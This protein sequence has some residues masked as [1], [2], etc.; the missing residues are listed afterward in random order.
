MIAPTADTLAA[1]LVLSTPSARTAAGAFWSAIRIAS[2]SEIFRALSGA[3]VS[4][5]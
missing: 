3:R 2:L 1:L 4:P 5:G